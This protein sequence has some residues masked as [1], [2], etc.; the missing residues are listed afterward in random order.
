M[1][2]LVLIVVVPFAILVAWEVAAQLQQRRK[3]SDSTGPMS[4]TDSE[5]HY[6]PE[7]ERRRQLEVRANR[8]PAPARW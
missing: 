3:W 6:S 8:W 5:G 1:S 7:L 4:V 2:V